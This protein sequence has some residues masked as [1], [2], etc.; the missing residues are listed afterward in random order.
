MTCLALVI[1]QTTVWSVLYISV[2]QVDIDH[3]II[4]VKLFI[5]ISVHMHII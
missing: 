2:G 5:C 1:K 3:N 4:E